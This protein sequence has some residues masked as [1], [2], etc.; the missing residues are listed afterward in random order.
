[1]E[2][3]P[4]DDTEKKIEK[5]RL[6]TEAATKEYEKRHNTYMYTKRLW[7]KTYV[8]IPLQ[9][10][11]RKQLKVPLLSLFDAVVKA[12]QKKNF[13]EMKHMFYLTKIQVIFFV[14]FNI[15]HYYKFQIETNQANT[16][17]WKNK[18]GQAAFHLLEDDINKYWR[19]HSHLSHFNHEEW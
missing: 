6:W 18:T 10:H 5:Y 14:L 2:K 16:L 9:P 3:I 12:E 8:E 15:S 7:N 13:M 19:K 4:V 11:V 1:M 17:V